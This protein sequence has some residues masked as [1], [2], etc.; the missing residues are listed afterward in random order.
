MCIVLFH[1]KLQPKQT[2]TVEIRTKDV[3]LIESEKWGAFANLCTINFFNLIEFINFI[4]CINFVKFFNFINLIGLFFSYYFRLT[5]VPFSVF[6]LLQFPLSLI[7]TSIFSSLSHPFSSDTSFCSPLLL[8]L[9]YH[10][11]V[12]ITYS[13]LSMLASIESL[14][15]SSIFLSFSFFYCLS[16]DFLLVVFLLFS[17]T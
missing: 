12:T 1:V 17:S 11:F 13:P 2:K 15:L 8:Y 7:S 10:I 16:V 3:Q 14:S 4:N 6:C 9:F 5:H